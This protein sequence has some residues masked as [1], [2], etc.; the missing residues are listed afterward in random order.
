VKKNRGGKKKKMETGDLALSKEKIGL[1]CKKVR[2]KKEK[3][4][5]GCIHGN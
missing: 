2:G 1:R 3:T 5:K 4:R